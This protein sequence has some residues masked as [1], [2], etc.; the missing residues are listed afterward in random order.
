MSFYYIK[1]RLRFVYGLS[2]RI[3]SVA[4]YKQVHHNNGTNT[5]WIGLYLTEQ[6][7]DAGHIHNTHI[8]VT[9]WK[10]VAS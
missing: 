10:K 8:Q 1:V 3:F 7:D 2:W 4:I 6:Y 5:I 9:K